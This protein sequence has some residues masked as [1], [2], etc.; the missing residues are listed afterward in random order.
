MNHRCFTL[1][2]TMVTLAAALCAMLPTLNGPTDLLSA[3]SV[4]LMLALSI[5]AFVRWLAL[6]DQK[7]RRRDARS[8]QPL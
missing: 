3:V 4:S 2:T 8:S 7:R 6:G 5:T 1:L